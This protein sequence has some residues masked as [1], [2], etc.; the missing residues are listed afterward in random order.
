MR[1]YLGNHHMAVECPRT[2]W[3]LGALNALTYLRYNRS[4]KCHVRD[5]V[6][7][8]QLI[9]NVQSRLSWADTVHNVDVQPVGSAAHCVDAFL[10]EG[11]KVGG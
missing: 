1:N 7:F 11:T 10:S 6:A 9:A 4:T 3:L 2:H 8:A 5:K